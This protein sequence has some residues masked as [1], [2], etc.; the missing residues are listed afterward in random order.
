FGLLRRDQVFELVPVERVQLAR[1]AETAPA[2]IRV[3]PRVRVRR[4]LVARS[5]RPPCL[6]QARTA[7]PPDRFPGREAT[8]GGWERAGRFLGMGWERPRRTSRHARTS[9]QGLAALRKRDP[10]RLLPRLVAL[11]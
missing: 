3:A 7:L 8:G 10:R 5:A 1:R 2:L 6:E 4:L 11:G 9:G